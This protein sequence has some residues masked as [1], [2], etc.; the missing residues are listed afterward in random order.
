MKVGTSDCRSNWVQPNERT[1]TE[2]GFFKAFDFLSG[3]SFMQH[4]LNIPSKLFGCPLLTCPH[5][6]LNCELPIQQLNNN[7]WLNLARR[8]SPN[9]LSES[10]WTF[11]CAKSNNFKSRITGLYVNNQILS[12][13]IDNV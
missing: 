10:M 1:T 12:D 4:N 7:N 2:S 8:Y 3:G 11:L 13:E 9:V 6:N 5:A